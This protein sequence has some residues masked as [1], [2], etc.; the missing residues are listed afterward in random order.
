MCMYVC[1]CV[2][3][4]C[5]SVRDDLTGRDIFNSQYIA[6]QLYMRVDTSWDK[7]LPLKFYTI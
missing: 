5:M 7:S 2:L 1:L 4:V 3:S 6:I